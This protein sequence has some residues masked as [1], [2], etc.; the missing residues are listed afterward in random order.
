M[1]DNLI[2]YKAELNLIILWKEHE[3]TVEFKKNGN[4]TVTSDFA[5]T[6]R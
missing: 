6:D 3:E 1:L 4:Q 2:R 5:V